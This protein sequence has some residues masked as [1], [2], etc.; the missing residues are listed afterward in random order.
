MA[1]AIGATANREPNGAWTFP[2]QIARAIE[3]R[4]PNLR[5]FEARTRAKAEAQVSWP[6]P[7]DPARAIDDAEY[8]LA[9]YARHATERGSCKYLEEAN[10][11]LF[12]SLRNR[13]RRWERAWSAMSVFS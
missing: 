13:Y 12:E 10:P 9:W 3:G 4:V 1:A 2:F 8:D 6:A 7:S 11:F 5:T